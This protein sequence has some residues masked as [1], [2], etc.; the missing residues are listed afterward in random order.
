[1]IQEIKFIILT[2][3]FIVHDQPSTHCPKEEKIWEQYPKG[4][5]SLDLRDFVPQVVRFQLLKPFPLPS[6]YMYAYI[7]CKTY[8]KNIEKTEIYIWY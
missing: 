3:P 6:I 1:M 5:F 8:K 2:H 4:Y 7:C